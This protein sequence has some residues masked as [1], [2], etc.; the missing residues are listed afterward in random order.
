MSLTV[1]IIAKVPRPGRVKRRLCPPLTH[2]EAAS[3]A[4]AALDD[5]IEVVARVRC[6]R[7]VLSLDQYSASLRPPGFDIV[8]Q[9]DSGFAERLAAAFEVSDGPTVLVGMDTPQVTPMLIESAFATLREPDDAALGLATDGGFWL[10][11]TARQ[12]PRAFEHVPMSSDRTGAAQRERLQELRLRVHMLP[13]LRDVDRIADAL[14][15]AAAA[16]ATRF[17][18]VMALLDP[19]ARTHAPAS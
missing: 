16:P 17:A 6:D 12:H 8:E 5:T 19:A 14:H 15:V 4:R 1:I 7:R 13:L 11:G 18:A 2:A 9:P 3:V 10:I